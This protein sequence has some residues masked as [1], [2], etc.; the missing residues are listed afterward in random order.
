M[1]EV[2][3]ENASAVC[4]VF[5]TWPASPPVA[6]FALALIAD[7]LAACVHVFDLGSSF[8]QWQGRVE[9]T[10]EHQVVIKTTRDRL[11]ALTAR[12]RQA[13]PYDLPELLVCDAEGSGAYAAWVRKSVEVAEPRQE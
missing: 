3:E 13:H 1:A 12:L 4:V 9:E 6:P 10:A 8:Y 2:Q 11:P 7:R 5:T